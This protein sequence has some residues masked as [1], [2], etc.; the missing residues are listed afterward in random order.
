MNELA[1]ELKKIQN[2]IDFIYKNILSH[3]LEKMFV[4]KITYIDYLN[5]EYWKYEIN[6]LNDRCKIIVHK[7]VYGVENE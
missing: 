4:G 2:E 1:Y 6:N 5:M 3:M 7:I